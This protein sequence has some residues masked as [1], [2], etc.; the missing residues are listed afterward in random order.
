MNP[1][2][3]HTFPSRL[4]CGLALACGLVLPASAQET[5]K[6]ARTFSW[7]EE[8]L[9]LF[10]TVAVMD[11]GRVKPLDTFAGFSLLRLNGKRSCRTPAKEKL[12]PVAWLLDCLFFPEDSR[13]YQVFRVANAEVLDA[14]GVAH[15]RK[16]KSD[17][18]S[19]QD[20]LP[21]RAA[22]FRLAQEIQAV[23]APERSP[24]QTQLYNLAHLVREYE[25][26]TGF[27]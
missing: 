26:L 1:T 10:A 24:V 7:N 9:K 25:T 17:R 11:R 3:A 15:E 13:G 8:T 18:Y 5:Q 4:A 19:Y 14:I 21:G 22:L 6:R 20:L 23:E 16:K 12:K 2:R 27:L